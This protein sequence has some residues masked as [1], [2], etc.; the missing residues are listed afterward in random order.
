MPAASAGKTFQPAVKIG[1]FQGVMASTTPSASRLTMTVWLDGTGMMR[2]SILSHQ[3][4]QYSAISATRAT[5]ARVSRKGLPVC[6]DSRRARL[7][8]YCRSKGAMAQSR[9][10]RS[11]PLKACQTPCARAALLVASATRPGSALRYSSSA[12]PVVG[13][14]KVM[15]A[16]S[17]AMISPSTRLPVRPPK[18]AV[19]SAVRTVLALKGVIAWLLQKALPKGG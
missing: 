6:A 18:S 3:P 1:A 16:P 11:A 5:S 19:T 13:S 8:A 7:S 4:A 10:P 14:C 2:P 12:S 9:R 17:P 15:F